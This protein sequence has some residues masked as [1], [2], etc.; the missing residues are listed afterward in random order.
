[1]TVET[2]NQQRILLEWYE[3]LDADY[4]EHNDSE[5][6]CQVCAEAIELGIIG[7][8]EPEENI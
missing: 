7:D 5:S 2:E 6:P 8:R 1:M 3:R 4:G